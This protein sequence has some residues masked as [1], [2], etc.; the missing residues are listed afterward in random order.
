MFLAKRVNDSKGAFRNLKALN[1]H[2]LR[3][4]PPIPLLVSQDAVIFNSTLLQLLF[5]ESQAETEAQPCSQDEK[6]VLGS[7]A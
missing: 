2:A 6:Q 7:M 3:S 4:P 1:E 5:R